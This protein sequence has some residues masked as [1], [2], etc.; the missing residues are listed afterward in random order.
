[1]SESCATRKECSIQKGST[2][3]SKGMGREALDLGTVY[4]AIAIDIDI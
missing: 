1:V 4:I 3:V 2:E